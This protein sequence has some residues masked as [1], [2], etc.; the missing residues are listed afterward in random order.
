MTL[1]HRT[2]AVLVVLFTAVGCSAD[3]P[4]E[5]APAAESTSHTSAGGDGPT[6]P[7]AVRLAL[8]EAPSGSS[9]EGV[10]TSLEVEV[11]NVGRRADS[12]LLRLL[13]PGVGG[14]LPES[15]R[16]RP[17]QHRPVRVMLSPSARE[18]SVELVAVSRATGDD[19]ETLELS[20]KD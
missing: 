18:D 10:A 5:P 2:A 12:Y 3:E 16:L 4:R 1:A 9:S 14:V 19:L 15:I 13:P 6:R 20:T 8:P 7:Y 17:G 11:E